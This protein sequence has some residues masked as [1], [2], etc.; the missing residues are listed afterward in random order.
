[1][2]DGRSECLVS[3][4]LV[5]AVRWEDE[6]EMLEQLVSAAEHLSKNWSSYENEC[7]E[8]EMLMSKL[9]SELDAV[10][11][12]TESEH[13]HMRLEQLQ[14]CIEYCVTSVCYLLLTLNDMSCT[15]AGFILSSS[16]PRK[17]HRTNGKSCTKFVENSTKIIVQ[18][19][20][21]I[22]WSW[23]THW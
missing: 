20:V 6:D 21:H 5:C 8:V 2:A 7:R 13:L 19:C 17:L 14:V 10:I 22:M 1:M 12:D 9:E 16:L 23:C 4:M 15:L 18:S 11:T 3:V